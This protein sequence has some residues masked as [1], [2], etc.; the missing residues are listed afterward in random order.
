MGD[1]NKSCPLVEDINSSYNPPVLILTFIFGFIGNAIALWVFSLHVKTWRSSTVYGLNLAIADTLL[2][3]A[4]PFRV[5]YYIRGKDWFFGDVACRLKIFTIF[6]NRAV[7]VA[8]LAVM[9]LE[10]YFKVIHP[11]HKVSKMTTSGAVKVSCIV[12]L[13]TLAMCLHVL[14]EARTFP[15]MNVTN[16]EP[17]KP[18][19]PLSPTA[20]FT[21][22]VF[23]IFNFLLPASIILFSTCCIAWKLKQMKSELM[24]KYNR[25]TRLVVVVATVFIICF[26]PSNVAVIAVLI[27]N[28]VSNCKTFD[29][30]VQVFCNTLCITYLNSVLDP[31]VYYFSSSTFKESLKKALI[32]HNIRLFRSTIRSA[33]PKPETQVEPQRSSVLNTWDH[34]RTESNDNL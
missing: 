27:S 29:V 1:E 7:S 21:N 4:L 15:H 18:F 8:F 34:L 3:C 14:T 25:A 17:F 19:K 2:I 28:H 31:F 24:G 20:I 33:P 26:L 10:R 9:A 16:C 23:I 13:V 32:S 30:T 5:D 22:M 11:H 6:M 12:W